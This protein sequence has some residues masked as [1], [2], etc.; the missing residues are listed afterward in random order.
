MNGTHRPEGVWVAT[1]AESQSPGARPSLRDVAPTILSA[2]GIPW[3]DDDAVGPDGADFLAPR[4]DYTP[5]E[6]ERVAARLRAL[7]YLE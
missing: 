4:Q 6:E 2:M 7:G 5:E 1:G 3:G